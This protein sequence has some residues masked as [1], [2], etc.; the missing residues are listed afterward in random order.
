MTPD[1]PEVE[2]L[3]R[4]AEHYQTESAEHRA[5]R[6]F[7]HAREYAALADLIE[8]IIPEDDPGTVYARA[9]TVAEVVLGE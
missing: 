8:A 6:A 4:L 9:L 5:W 1:R 3:R 7:E 2:T